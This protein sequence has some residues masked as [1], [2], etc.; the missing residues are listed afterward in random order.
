MNTHGTR[1]G[2]T[3]PRSSPSLA[4]ARSVGSSGSDVNK[5][6]SQ[7]SSQKAVS[8]TVLTSSYRGWHFCVRGLRPLTHAGT[9]CG[10]P[11]RTPN[12]GTQ[13]GHPIPNEGTKCGH[14]MSPPNEHTQTRDSLGGYAPSLASLT[15]YRS[16][17]RVV[18]Q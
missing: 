16:F 15:R 8:A 9:K 5:L 13:C 14:P 1:S 6:P 11:I 7:P 2:A 4:V 12:V 10:H 17:G 18:G 3:P